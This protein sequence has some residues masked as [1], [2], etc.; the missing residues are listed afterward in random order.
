M[1]VTHTWALSAAIAIASM[2]ATPSMQSAPAPAPAASAPLP[3]KLADYKKE[4]AA[5]VD[6]MYDLAQQMEIGR[7]HV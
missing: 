7:A 3:P 6:G 1:R 4:A 5:S 2:S